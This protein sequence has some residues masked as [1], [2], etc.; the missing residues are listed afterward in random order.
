MLKLE[1]DFTKRA[2]NVNSFDYK[3]TKNNV[4]CFECLRMFHN[5]ITHQF[6]SKAAITVSRNVFK[7]KDKFVSSVMRQ[8]SSIT[9]LRYSCYKIHY[10]TR[11]SCKIYKESP[12][13]SNVC[14][15]LHNHFLTS[16]EM[17]C[18]FVPHETCQEKMKT[19]I[20]KDVTISW[21]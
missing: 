14:F 1:F 18:Y 2:S 13:S 10:S 17:K 5:I 20:D 6:N 15:S 3:A 7:Q 4:Q 21:K 16:G 19:Y 12:S 9:A 8:I 11:S